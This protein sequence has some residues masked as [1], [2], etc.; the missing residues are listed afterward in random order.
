MLYEVVE[1]SCSLNNS[2]HVMVLGSFVSFM[3]NLVQ[4]ILKVRLGNG[5]LLQKTISLEDLKSKVKK[6]NISKG[7]VVLKNIKIPLVKVINYFN[8]VVPHSWVDLDHGFESL[9]F[10][11]LFVL[12][13]FFIFPVDFFQEIIQVNF[14][15]TG[16][17]TSL[18]CSEVKPLLS[19]HIHVFLF[20]IHVEVQFVEFIGLYDLNCL[21]SFLL[22]CQG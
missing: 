20:T 1:V 11:D 3:R 15:P 6:R 5:E 2:K 17:V 10:L 19:I 13:N 18:V 21:E 16:C 7:F 9:F 14:K 8:N 4:Q 12:I 22:D